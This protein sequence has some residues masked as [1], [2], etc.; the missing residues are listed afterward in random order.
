MENLILTE[1]SINIEEAIQNSSASSVTAITDV[2]IIQRN[3]LRIKIRR[4]S[5]GTGIKYGGIVYVFDEETGQKITETKVPGS[6]PELWAT[7]KDNK[8]DFDEKSYV[9]GYGPNNTD[10]SINATAATVRVDSGDIFD[11]NSSRCYKLNVRNNRV[12]AKYRV[13]NDFANVKSMRI[14]LVEGNELKD[15]NHAVAGVIY[16][17]SSS[18]PNQGTI[19]LNFPKGKELTVGKTYTLCLNVYSW[20]RE[21]AGQYFTFY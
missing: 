13:P 21:I 16:K 9:I 5:T 4:P 10:Q 15:S 1:N 6:E 20:T 18:S 3:E 12:T 7:I 2:Q 8:L 19:H 17:F 14:Y 11:F